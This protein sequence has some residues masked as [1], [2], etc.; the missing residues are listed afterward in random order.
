MYTPTPPGIHRVA[1][2][3]KLYAS[4]TMLQGTAQQQRH[5]KRRSTRWS[6]SVSRSVFRFGWLID[7]AL[8]H[9]GRTIHEALTAIGS[10]LTADTWLGS[11]CSCQC[12][13]ADRCRLLKSHN[14]GCPS[15]KMLGGCQPAQHRSPADGVTREQGGCRQGTVHKQTP[16][17]H[18]ATSAH[19][20]GVDGRVQVGR[21]ACMRHSTL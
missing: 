4:A 8:A 16:C 21:R 15:T 6:G 9:K 17:Q 11:R 5:D 13:A 19:V 2:Q 10:A 1:T 12:H 20:F 3:P 18:C 7:K 14:S